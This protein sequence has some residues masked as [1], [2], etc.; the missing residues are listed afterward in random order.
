MRMITACFARMH[1]KCTDRVE[2]GF[3]FMLQEVRPIGK[4]CNQL[5]CKA[6]GQ[7]LLFKGQDFSQTDIA[8]V[9]RIRGEDDHTQSFEQD[10][11]EA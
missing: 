2:L 4:T 6:T 8:T 3:L 1:Q 5:L 7:P 10:E 11:S 9:P